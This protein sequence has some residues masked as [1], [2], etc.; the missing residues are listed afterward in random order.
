[1]S[2]LIKGM[3]MP[4]SC[5]KCPLGHINAKRYAIECYAEYPTKLFD[6]E[7]ARHGINPFCP[8][9]PVP[10]HGRLIDADALD[11]YLGGAVILAASEDAKYAYMDVQ[12]K[13]NNLQTII[14]ADKEDG[15]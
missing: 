11:K 15:K 5:A 9:F 1:M 14:P 6:Y 4:K 8:L 12:E 13:L 7:L 2:I 3:E 10:D